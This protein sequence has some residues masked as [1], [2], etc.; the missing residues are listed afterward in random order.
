MSLGFFAQITDATV[1]LVTSHGGPFV[2]AGIGMFK[3]IASALIVWEGFLIAFRAQPP[4]R[5][6]SLMV[7]MCITYS[8]L[9]F[10]SAPFP[11]VGRNLTQIITDAG[12]DMANQMDTAT[13][14]QVGRMISGM[15]GDAGAS[16]WNIIEN[17][18][19]NVRYFIVIFA[20]SGMQIV[21][22]AIIAYGFVAQGVLV[23]VG[24]IFI[25]FLM[26]PHMEW[27]ATSWF[28]CLIQY[29]FYPVIGNAFIFVYGTVWLNCF[30]QIHGDFTV[31][32]I[33]AYFVYIL[34]FSAAGIFGILKVPRLV[35]EIFSGS[36]GT[37]A[38]PAIGWW[39]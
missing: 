31:T 30:S 9:V 11:I 16:S 37:S 2:S 25:P 35:A 5:L 21:M 29:A 33:A 28:R 1:S 3:G 19:A 27:I 38:V 6:A 22:L 23:L 36:S 13:E 15:T 18:M 4:S 20:L 7:T 26:V 32:Q 8:A 10:Y 12:T 17:A 14:E 39:R 24:P 34:V